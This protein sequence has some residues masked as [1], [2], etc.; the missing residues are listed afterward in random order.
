M[1]WSLRSKLP[2]QNRNAVLRPLRGK[3]SRVYVME[4]A[5][6]SPEAKPQRGFATPSGEWKRC[7]FHGVCAAI[8]RSKTATRFCDPFGGRVAVYMLW[9]LRNK[10]PKQNRNAVSF[11]ASGERGGRPA[12]LFAG[13]FRPG[14]QAESSCASP[15]SLRAPD[16]NGR[17]RPPKQRVLGRNNA[18]CASLTDVS[19]P[20]HRRF[21]R[22]PAVLAGLRRPRPRRLAAAPRVPGA[23]APLCT[24]P[25]P[26][27]AAR[28]L[29]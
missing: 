22:N 14:G 9:S 7:I 29:W 6:Q 26:M 11:R 20:F 1:P 13:G 21:P 17:K 23:P 3:G 18:L 15:A 10:L 24:H 16:A 12:P 4:F 8:S 25:P 2:K 27:F 5:Q 19:A 28:P